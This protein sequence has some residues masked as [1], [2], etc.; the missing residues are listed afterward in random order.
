MTPIRPST[1]FGTRPRCDGAHPALVL[2]ER[3]EHALP[4]NSE[5]DVP[6]S[7]PGLLPELI[8]AAG[9]LGYLLQ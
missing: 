8:R 1:G 6:L 9:S 7:H 2:F 3:A 4:A 5:L